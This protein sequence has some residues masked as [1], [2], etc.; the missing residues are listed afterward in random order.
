MP[1]LSIQILKDKNCAAQYICMSLLVSASLISQW[2]RLWL[3]YTVYDMSKEG[4]SWP[5]AMPPALGTIKS[6]KG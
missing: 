5:R 6:T 1:F 3:I 4:H 2:E